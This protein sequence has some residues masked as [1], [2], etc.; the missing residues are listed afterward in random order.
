MTSTR[1][2]PSASAALVDAGFRDADFGSLGVPDVPGVR[3]RFVDAG[4]LRM[5]VA[6]AG[7]GDPIVMLHGWPQHWYL[8]RDVIPLVAP[9]ARLICPERS[10]SAITWAYSCANENR[11]RR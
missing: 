7:E 4:G 6:E 2:E 1:A 10:R 3:H 9:H 11:R 8:W 5:H